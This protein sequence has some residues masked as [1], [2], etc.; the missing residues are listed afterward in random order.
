MIGGTLVSMFTRTVTS[1]PTTRPAASA[2]WRRRHRLFALCPGGADLCRV[3]LPG[4][5]VEEWFGFFAPA[6]T[7]ASV[8]GQ[9]ERSHQCR[10]EGQDGHRQP[11]ISG[12]VPLGGTPEA[13]AADLKRVTEVGPD[14]QPTGFT[15]RVLNQEPHALPSA[16]RRCGRLPP[17]WPPVQLQR[18]K[19]AAA[20]MD[21]AQA[22]TKFVADGTRITGGIGPRRLY[23]S[24]AWRSL[25]PMPARIVSS[26]GACTNASAA[27]ASLR[28]RFR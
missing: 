11:A 12:L 5:V 1:W 20:R 4:P 21:C 17:A 10:A 18:A 7:P 27:T 6:R 9:R 23:R 26:P 3:G 24:A 2:S 13:M 25:Y 16:R 19:M 22:A 28:H 8:V 15:R 14:R